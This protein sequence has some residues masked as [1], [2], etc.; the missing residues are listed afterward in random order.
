MSLPK[1]PYEVLMY[2][3]KWFRAIGIELDD[4]W[5]EF[6]LRDGT[7]GMKPRAKWRYR[8]TTKTQTRSTT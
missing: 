3:D 5:L 6:Q 4:G 7:V 2:G 8:R 1:Y